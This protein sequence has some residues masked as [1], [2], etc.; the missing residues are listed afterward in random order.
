[1]A[2]LL[3]TNSKVTLAVQVAFK[4]EMKDSVSLILLKT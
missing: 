4:V 1:M 2:S 3:I